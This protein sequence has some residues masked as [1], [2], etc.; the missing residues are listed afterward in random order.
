MIAPIDTPHEFIFVADV[1][2]AL[3]ALVAE[4]QAYGQA[5]H[6]AGPGMITTREFAPSCLRRGWP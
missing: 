6:L 5:W 2:K 1:A 4:E 3:V